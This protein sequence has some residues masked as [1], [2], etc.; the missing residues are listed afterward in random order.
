MMLFLL[1]FLGAV[2]AQLV[3]PWW[4]VGPVAF[5]L[6]FWRGQ[7]G[8][9]AFL[10]GFSGVGLSW[11]LPA[12]WWQVHTGSILSQRVAT[13][14]PLGGNGWVLALV[15]AVLAGLLGGLAALAGVW[16]RQAFRP[17]PPQP[18]TADASMAA[19]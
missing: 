6:S 10:A 14:L 2:V 16:L 12:A 19:K 9:R 18:A 15:A 17:R 1:I 8:G 3:L 5:V 7:T 4:I 13:L 11:L